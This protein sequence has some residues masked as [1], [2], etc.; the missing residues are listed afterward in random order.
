[1]K[2]HHLAHL[3]PQSEQQGSG[4]WSWGS[5]GPVDTW[6][7]PIM[8]P[9]EASKS[10]NECRWGRLLVSVCRPCDAG[11][12]SR[13]WPA[14]RPMSTRTTILQR[15]NA[16]DC[17]WMGGTYIGVIRATYFSVW[18][19]S[20]PLT[21]RRLDT[22]SHCITIKGVTLWNNCGD[23]TRTCPTFHKF[24]QMIQTSMV[25]RQDMGDV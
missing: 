4:Q 2:R 22:K 19:M 10:R 1:M 17:G 14:S 21:R 3:E 9:I 15:L 16:I 18:S 5:W 23:K 13:V 8:K 24:Y 11:D 20:H 25:N 7:P 12:L 6:T